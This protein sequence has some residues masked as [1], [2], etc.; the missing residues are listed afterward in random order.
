M[1]TLVTGYEKAAQ[2]I[3]VHLTSFEGNAR[4]AK[5]VSDLS[6]EDLYMDDGMESLLKRLD[7]VYKSDK[8]DEAYDAYVK[9]I[10]YEKP[11]VTFS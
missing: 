3:M 8:V 6:A 4:A 9:F 10:S 7:A 11:S 2:A 5:A 1:W